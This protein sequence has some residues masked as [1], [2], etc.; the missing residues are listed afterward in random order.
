VHSFDERLE[1]PEEVEPRRAGRGPG[2][3]R[4]IPPPITIKSQGRSSSTNPVAPAA[5]PHVV[6]DRR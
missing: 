1:V 2:R 6:S 4:G 3:L 5:F